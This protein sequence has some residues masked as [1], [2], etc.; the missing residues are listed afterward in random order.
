MGI[1]RPATP[2]FLVTLIAT[3]L[4]A[5]VSF[6]VPYFKTIFFLK[7]SLSVEGLN[8]SIT[9]GT[10]GYCLELSNGTTCSKPS[11]GYELN[12][13]Q[14]LGNNLPV[15]IP[16]VVVKW[17]TYA[18]VL[19]VVALILAAISSLFGLLAHVREMSMTCFSTCIS[20]FAASIAL[21]AFIFDL[22]LFFVAK[23]RMNSVQGGSATMGLGIWLTLAAW[24]LL[25][26]SGCF[27]G[28]G[29]CCIS[30]RPRSTWEKKDD[31]RWN[32]P[33]A[34]A[35]PPANRYD[36]ELR[37]EAV[38]AE[39][40][41]KARQAQGEGG[42]PAF[43]EFHQ[44]NDPSQPLK[45]VVDGDHVYLEDQY[46]HQPYRDTDVESNRTGVSGPGVV[47]AGAY[48]RQP[49][50]QP[51]RNE[52]AG[53]YAQGPQG[54]RAVDEYYSPTRNQQPSQSYPPQP[55]RQGSGATQATTGYTPST[56]TNAASP[57]M[58][59]TQPLNQYLA[60]GRQYPPQE[61]YPERAF[62]HTAGGTSYHSAASQVQAESTFYDPYAARHQEPSYN[63]D[64]YNATAM[65]ASAPSRSPPPHSPAPTSLYNPHAAN[66]YYSPP[67]SPPSQQL[68]RSYTLGGGGYGANVV[69]ALHDQQPSYV[70]GYG[71]SNQDAA[72][73][74]LP[75][76][77]EQQPY[78]SH[79]GTSAHTTPAPVPIN[80]NVAG[81]S[82]PTSPIKGPRSPRRT[83]ASPVQYEDSPPGY[84]DV[85]RPQPSGG[86]DRKR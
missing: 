76:S 58:P 70:Q 42:L 34:G 84:E 6:S 28:I 68:E 3:I 65:L 81:Q 20:G 7:A 51:S 53:G 9:F 41:R 11:V 33:A 16:V 72:A 60:P 61:Q 4:L 29:K 2:G 43:H 82:G 57:P 49:N 62:G 75:Y 1:I 55:R 66:T 31:N 13:N 10:L 8:G 69:P 19:H 22:I 63:P 39:A 14:L 47:G 35:V 40:D 5:V 64:T 79:P 27:F 48:G 37:L 85:G 17:L 25:F 45:A 56:Y 67:H 38:K 86:W 78:Y 77:G 80:T 30:R 50:R 21:I 26:F 18:L 83:V 74:Y 71:Q 12:V 46:P 24:I 73:A 54:S 44:E 23:S 59:N 32:P 15:Q 36:E 52:Y